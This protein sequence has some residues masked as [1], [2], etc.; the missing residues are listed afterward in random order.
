VRHELRTASHFATARPHDIAGRP[1]ASVW[2]GAVY[3]RVRGSELP[4]LPPFQP[5]LPGTELL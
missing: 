4:A 2:K 1:I 5:K 3:R